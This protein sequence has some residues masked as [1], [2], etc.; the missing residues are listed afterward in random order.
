MKTT[1]PQGNEPAMPAVTRI[2]IRAET[3]GDI[4][5]IRLVEA[6]A[7]PTHA[8]ADLVDRLR[9]D[10]C[11]VLSLIAVLDRQIIGHA[12]LSR[13]QEPR[14]SLGLGPVAVLSAHRQRGVAAGLIREGLSRAK[15]DGW[16]A[17]FVL[18]DPA[19]YGRFG[20]SAALAARFGSPYA[21]RH[22]MG[23]ELQS[24]GLNVRTGPLKYA[25]A[26]ADLE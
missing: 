22:L 7:F 5:G 24:D 26:F 8:E 16:V 20:F 23:L 4:A 12:M 11:T 2:D 18:G 9:D 6:E 15:A 10:G 21:G 14:G 25:Q 19:Y 17:I 3:P 1:M 13:M